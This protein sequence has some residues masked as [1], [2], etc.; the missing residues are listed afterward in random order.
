MVPVCVV[1]ANVTPA[2]A[3]VE[4]SAG[5]A[6]TE[7]YTGGNIC[8]AVT[9]YITSV[10]WPGSVDFAIHAILQ[11]IY[12]PFKFAQVVIQ[13]MHM[14]VS[15]AKLYYVAYYMLSIPSLH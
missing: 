15:M 8:F 12:S 5:T 9:I 11:L 4:I 2:V 7:R 1:N 13:N 6:Q 10:S 3:L 14:F